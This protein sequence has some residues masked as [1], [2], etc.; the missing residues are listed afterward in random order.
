MRRAVVPLALVLAL[1]SGVVLAEVRL[2]VLAP[3]PS[4]KSDQS[5]TDSA[6]V[7]HRFYAA[8]NAALSSGNPAPLRDAVGADFVDHA[9]RPGVGP[10]RAGL[11]RTVGALHAVDPSLRLTVA[12]VFAAGDR[13]AARVGPTGDGDAAFLGVPVPAGRLWDSV[14]VF[15]VA[16]GRVVEH[17]GDPAS[18][19]LLAPLAAVTVP[20]ARPTRAAVTLERWAYA[21]DTAEMW[22]TGEGFVILL[23]DA[24]TL[25]VAVDPTSEGAAGVAQQ[26]GDG[27]ASGDRPVAPGATVRLAVGEAVV[28]PA[29]ALVALRDDGA[30]PAVALAVVAVAPVVRAGAEGGPAGT[31]AP[32]ARTALAGPPTAVGTGTPVTR[33]VLAG[34]PT[35]VLPVGKATVA[36]GRAALG[37]GTALPAHRVDV[38]EMAAVEAGVLAVTADGGAWVTDTRDPAVDVRRTDAATVEAGG[39]A[40]AEARTAVGYAA[41][42]TPRRGCYW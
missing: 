41:A 16:E 26:G 35:A 22:A 10:D 14:D 23:V 3:T 13:V 24:G 30:A 11:L 38:T 19:V 39:G 33:T 29:R 7:V 40:Y 15:R 27:L 5:T 28:V 2:L 21:P 18:S 37:A 1:A 34:G 25:T 42:G 8:V 36:L 32:V 17:W 31:G 9:P 20:V 6:A 12:D 4:L